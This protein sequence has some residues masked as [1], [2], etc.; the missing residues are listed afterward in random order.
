MRASPAV[1]ALGSHE[2]LASNSPTAFRPPPMLSA[3]ATATAAF[4]PVNFRKPLDPCSN[5]H[6]PITARRRNPRHLSARRAGLGRPYR[7]GRVQAQLAIHGSAADPV[8]WRQLVWQSPR[9]RPLGGRVDKFVATGR[10]LSP[11]GMTS[12]TIARSAV[13]FHLARFIEQVRDPGRPDHRAQKWQCA[14]NG[15]HHDR[16]RARLNEYARATI[17]RQGRQ[18]NR[19][20]SKVASVIR[21]STGFSSASPGPNAAMRTASLASNRTLVRHPSPSPSANT[22]RR[23]AAQNPLGIFIN[24]IQ[25]VKGLGQ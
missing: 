16:R 8:G 20:R 2:T 4:P 10:R 17:L 7:L 5:D 13:A 21:A 24:A 25:L 19:S 1:P 23:C 22:R 6:R 15:I 11:A 14:M 9:H 3:P 12:P 18:S